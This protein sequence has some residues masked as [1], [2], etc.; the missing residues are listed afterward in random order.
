MIN[1]MVG[2][3]VHAIRWCYGLDQL[4]RGIGHEEA[5]GLGDK[6]VKELLA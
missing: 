3:V 6:E 4:E 1:P 2:D 5:K